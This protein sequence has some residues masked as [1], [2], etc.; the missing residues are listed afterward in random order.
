MSTVELRGVAKRYGATPVLHD[1]DLEV[2][3]GSTTAILGASGSGKTTLLRLVA[4]FDQIDAG[5]VSIGGRTMD[6]GH[7][8]TRAQDRGVGYVPQE[9]ALFPHL[10]VAGN[11]G[12]GVPRRQRDRVADLITMVGLD[13][14]ARRYPHELSG[15]QQQRVALARALAIRPRVV[16]LDEPFSSLDATLR[17]SLRRDMARVLAETGTTALVVTHDEDEALSVADQVA[18]LSEGRVMASASPHELYRDPPDLAAAR[19]IGEANI[20]AAEVQGQRAICV[21]G[22]IVLKE[23]QPPAGDGPARLLLRPEQL[24]VH[25]EPTDGAV[26]AI[27]EAIQYHGHDTLIDLVVD[28]AER[29]LVVDNAEHVTLVARGPGDLVLSIGQVVWITVRGAGRA[30]GGDDLVVHTASE[31]DPSDSGAC[32]DSGTSSDVGS[33]TPGADTHRRLSD[34][35]SDTLSH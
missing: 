18:V 31:L 20:L 13:G 21:L 28:D 35:T 24:V 14:L 33:S 25:V 26:G 19:A 5:T 16:L 32:S 6:D 22:S 11:I 8:F 10:T 9:G 23:R 29:D 3:D 7:H 30:W 1:V 17:T 2:P 27:V 15:G 34:G 12:F 4:G